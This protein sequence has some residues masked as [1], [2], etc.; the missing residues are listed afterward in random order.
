MTVNDLTSCYSGLNFLCGQSG[1][2]TEITYIDVVEIPGGGAW[3]SPGNFVITTGYFIRSEEDFE[4]LLISLI[5]N[6]ASGLGIKIGKYV[7][8]IPESVAK[9]AETNRFPILAIP[10]ELRYRDIQNTLN[11]R[12]TRFSAEPRR[13]TATDFYSQAIL[14]P[15]DTRGV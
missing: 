11:L 2:D 10:L 5:E 12:T 6:K 15:F 8:Q 7:K 3:I 13:S 4:Q 14:A 9:L 1:R